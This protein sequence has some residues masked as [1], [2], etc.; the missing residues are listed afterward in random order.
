VAAVV[1]DAGDEPAI[2]A[3]DEVDQIGAAMVNL[4]VNQKI[5]RRPDSAMSSSIRTT[6]SKMRSSNVRVSPDPGNRSTNTSK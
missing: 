6:G 3:A 4:A 5:I 2:V 1:G